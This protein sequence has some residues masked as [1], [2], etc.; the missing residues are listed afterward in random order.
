MATAR[1]GIGSAISAVM[2][3]LGVFVAVRL[4]VRPANPLTGTVVLDI[5]FALF[6]IARGAL[7]FWTMRRRAR[8]DADRGPPPP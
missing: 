8:A 2:I 6:F 3:A 5:A 7:F 4:L 1:F